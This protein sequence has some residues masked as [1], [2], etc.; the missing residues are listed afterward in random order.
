MAK[1]VLVTGANGYI[2]S[3]V[4]KKLLDMGNRVIAADFRFDNVDPQAEHCTEAIFSGKPDIYQRLGSPDVCIH[5]AWRDGF[6]HNSDAHMRDLS[7]HITFLQDMIRGGLPALAVMGTMHEIGYWEG[8]VDENTPCRPLSQYGVAKNALRQSLL[9]TSQQTNCRLLWLR[10][11]YITGDDL[12]NH[13]I[14]AK[15]SEAAAKGQKTF[16][17]TTGQN[18]F[19]FVDVDYLAEMIAVASTQE[20]ESG[21]INV[22]TGKPM[23]LAERVEKFIGDNH[24]DITLQYGAFPDRP[25]DSPGIWGDAE[26]INRIMAKHSGK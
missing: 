24:F 8:A 2:G 17:F 25:Y 13:S 6:V 23:T 22:C 21:I 7:G 26:K 1:T 18:K 4:V 14:F 19:D 20:E 12:H 11:Y 10:A 5:M 3:H 15:I 9:L 16:P